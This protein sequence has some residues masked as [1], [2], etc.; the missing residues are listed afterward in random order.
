MSFNIITINTYAPVL[1]PDEE[2]PDACSD[3][4]NCVLKMYTDGVAEA[5]MDSILL[6]RISLNLLYTTII[7]TII[8]ELTASLM[9]DAYGSLKE[10][11]AERDADKYNT[12]YICA[13]SKPDVFFNLYLDGKTIGNIQKTYL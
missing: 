7:G 6:D 8:G 12:C 11:D 5:E 1:Y 4:L 2:L 13:L 9:I 3:L 10:A